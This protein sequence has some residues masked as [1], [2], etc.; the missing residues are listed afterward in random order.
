VTVAREA[1]A[2]QVYRQEDFKVRSEDEELTPSVFTAATR[3]A[4]GE[5]SQSERDRRYAIRK[6]QAGEDPQKIIRE[7]GLPSRCSFP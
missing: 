2:A 6:L 4:A 1:P 5:Q 3:R 7:M